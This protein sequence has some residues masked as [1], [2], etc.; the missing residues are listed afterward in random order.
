MDHEAKRATKGLTSEKKTLPTYLRKPLLINPAAVKREH[1]ESQMKKWKGEWKGTI[2]G[3]RAECL[4]GSTLS[5]KFL[6]AISQKELSCNDASQLAQFRLRHAPVNQYL[7]RIRRVDSVRCPMCGDEEEMA[8]H[9]MLRCPAYAHERWA[10]TEKAKKLRKLMDMEMLLG[11]LE[12]TNKV[13]KY[14][15]AS[16]QFQQ[17]DANTQIDTLHTPH[18]THH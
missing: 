17:P 11:N 8:E 10:L 18:H 4:D 13:A 14:I 7:K 15:R 3:Q 2:R 6:N 16:N 1:H 9:F 5:R 12:M